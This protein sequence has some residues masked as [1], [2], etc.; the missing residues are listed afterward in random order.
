MPARSRLSSRWKTVIR[1][2]AAVRKNSAKAS[3]PSL[4]SESLSISSVRKT[5]PQR[6]EF[7]ET[8]YEWE[9]GRGADKTRLSED[10][11]AEAR[12]RC[13]AAAGRR[14]DFE[15]AAPTSR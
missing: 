5:D 9:R 15:I 13:R 6:T 2:C 3:G 7:R 11:M 12:H 14:R 8:Q 4:K 10:R 1:C